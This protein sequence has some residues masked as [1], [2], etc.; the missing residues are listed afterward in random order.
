M[1]LAAHNLCV[2]LG[3]CFA[4]TASAQSIKPGLWEVSGKEKFQACI[5]PEEAKQGIV[6]VQRQGKCTTKTSPLTGNTASITFTCTAPP[7]SGEGQVTFQSDTAYTMT[8]LIKGQQREEQMSGRWLSACSSAPV[9]G[10]NPTVKVGLWEMTV[11]PPDTDMMFAGMPPDERK[12]ME[13]AMRLAAKQVQQ[14][15]NAAMAGGDATQIPGY[16]SLSPD[17]RKEVDATMKRAKHSNFRMGEMFGYVFQFCVKPEDATTITKHMLAPVP[18]R[19]KCTSNVSP[20][21]S[22][23]LK[24]SFTCPSVSGKAEYTFGGGSPY[25]TWTLSLSARNNQCGGGGQLQASARWLSPNCGSAKGM[26]GADWCKDGATSC[27]Y[28]SGPSKGGC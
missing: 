24:A 25:T 21:V 27:L 1:R 11:S 19:E 6:P 4:V 13:E 2:L 14:I 23:K 18:Q 16:E 8:L 20:L 10:V 12:E 3:V 9:T 28:V 17:Q 26:D 7:A 22:N 15:N 5:T